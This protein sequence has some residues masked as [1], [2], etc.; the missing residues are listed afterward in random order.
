MWSEAL[1]VYQEEEESFLLNTNEEKRFVC[2]RRHLDRRAIT[3]AVLVQLLL[4]A[5]YTAAM[6]PFVTRNEQK[7]PISVNG[8][9]TSI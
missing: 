8:R 9:P 5:V 3:V 6:V 1:E 2:H 4:L 7:T